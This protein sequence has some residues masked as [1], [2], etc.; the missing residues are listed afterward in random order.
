M[1][2]H[3]SN[4]IFIL[5][6]MQQN[7]QAP[8]QPVGFAADRRAELFSKKDW[9][10]LFAIHGFFQRYH[11]LQ[12][13]SWTLWI[14]LLNSAGDLLG[15][16]LLVF[17]FFFHHQTEKHDSSPAGRKLCKIMS[18]SHGVLQAQRGGTALPRTAKA[19]LL[20]R[21][22]KF[23]STRAAFSAGLCGTCWQR[24]INALISRAVLFETHKTL[25][26]DALMITVILL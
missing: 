5:P 13:S 22:H 11:L 10:P 26:S 2:L 9:T 21:C 24:P 14:F 23:S 25:F 15:S 12:F 7:C 16:V 17:P 20:Q 19:A 3:L 6:M 8:G 18:Q 1:G 4:L